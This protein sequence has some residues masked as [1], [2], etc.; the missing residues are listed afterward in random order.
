MIKNSEWVSMVD[1]PSY[2][3]DYDTGISTGEYQYNI[4]GKQER[5]KYTSSNKLEDLKA[6]IETNKQNMQEGLYTL[7]NHATTGYFS[8]H[9]TKSD[10]TRYYR[11]D[12]I[13]IAKESCPAKTDYLYNAKGLKTRSHSE[14][15]IMRPLLNCVLPKKVKKLGKDGGTQEVNIN[16]FNTY[17][18]PC[19]DAYDEYNKSKNIEKRVRCDTFLRKAVKYYSNDKQALHIDVNSKCNIYKKDN[20]WIVPPSE[21]VTSYHPNT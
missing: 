14:T 18:P 8:I 17:Y 5:I 15:A 13:G 10:K 12:N 11:I 20:Q 4:N 7:Y 9:N 3:S 19:N 6:G 1:D 21:Y 16:L 2:D